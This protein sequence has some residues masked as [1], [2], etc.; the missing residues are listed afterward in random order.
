MYCVDIAL[1]SSG[2]N[3]R[4]CYHQTRKED[5]QEINKTLTEIVRMHKQNTDIFMTFRKFFHIPELF[6]LSNYEFQVII[7]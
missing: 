5:D 2:N 1:Y 4:L 7:H 6:F 3:Q